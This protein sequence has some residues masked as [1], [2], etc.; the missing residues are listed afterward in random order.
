M[1]IRLFDREIPFTLAEI[2]SRQRTALIAVDLQND[3][4]SPDG[5]AAAHGIDVDRVRRPLPDILGF[6]E[7]ARPLVAL[8]VFTRNTQDRNGRYLS[9]AKLSLLARRYSEVPRWAIE[10][11]WGHELIPELKIHD[12]DLVVN[13]TKH[14]AFADTQ[15]DF[16]LRANKIQTAVIVGATTSGCIMYT[17]RDA[18]M[19]DYFVCVATDCIGS[20]RD[21]WHEASLLLMERLFHYVGPAAGLLTVWNASR[22]PDGE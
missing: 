10:G 11:T 19:R 4:M 20:Q 22:D 16:L 14:S 6:I 13:K 2:A 5:V 9:D 3:Y 8:T 21:D 15:L 7:A 12:T 17:A 18:A 1:T